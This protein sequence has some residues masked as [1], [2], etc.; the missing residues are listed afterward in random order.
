MDVDVNVEMFVQLI[1]YRVWVK[2]LN[3]ENDGKAGS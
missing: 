2:V 1:Q 3:A